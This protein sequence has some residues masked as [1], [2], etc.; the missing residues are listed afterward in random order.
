MTQPI[1]RAAEEYL[2]KRAEHSIS[3]CVKELKSLFPDNQV[4]R[5]AIRT[6][7]LKQDWGRTYKIAKA[8]LLSSK[9]RQDRIAFAQFVK[10]NCFNDD[11]FDSKMRLKHV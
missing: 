2:R 11:N 6:W 9:N 10:S 5:E 7:S 8:P 4:G 3:G 1:K